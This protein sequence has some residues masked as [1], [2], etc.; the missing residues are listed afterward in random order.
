ML[1]ITLAWITV[2]HSSLLEKMRGDSLA[3]LFYVSNW[4]YIYH[5]LSYFD[6]FNLLSP[7]NHFWSLAV[8]EQFYVVWPFIISLGLYYIKTIPYDFINLSG[9]R[10]FSFSDG[11]M[12]LELIRAEYI[13]V[14]IRGPFP[15]LSERYLP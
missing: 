11:N 2:F 10:C 7:L 3:A 14:Q 4:W 9:S 6:N 15:Y 13:M 1:V 12:N 5:K 8:E